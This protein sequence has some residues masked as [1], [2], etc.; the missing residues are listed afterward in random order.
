MVSLAGMM[1]ALSRDSLC[2]TL[3]HT[4]LP[5]PGKYVIEACSGLLKRSHRNCQAPAERSS[6]KRNQPLL[7]SRID[8]SPLGLAGRACKPLKSRAVSECGVCSLPARVGC[9]RHTHFA[10]I[11]PLPGSD[12]V[13]GH[14]KHFAHDSDQRH[15][16]FHPTL[17][18]TM[19]VGSKGRA[20]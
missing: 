15:A 12:E 7:W 6:A 1:I 9:T 5:C 17:H 19:V 18:Q 4:M 3:S 16:L 13:S 2:I 10:R 20:W 14:G 8:K 11:I